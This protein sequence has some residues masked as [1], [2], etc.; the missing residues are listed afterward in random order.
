MLDP[1]ENFESYFS[2]RPRLPF[3]VRNSVN[4]ILI[5]THLKRS[6]DFARCCAAEW[7]LSNLIQIFPKTTF[8]RH[9]CEEAYKTYTKTIDARERNLGGFDP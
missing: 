3:H 1:V 9:A 7:F 5:K 2:R 4:S 6:W 8:E